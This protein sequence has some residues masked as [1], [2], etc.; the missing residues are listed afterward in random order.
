MLLSRLTLEQQLAARDPMAR[1]D[2]A[3][4][5]AIADALLGDE[6]MPVETVLRLL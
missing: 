2:T 1:G 3:T 5:A 4:E 6:R